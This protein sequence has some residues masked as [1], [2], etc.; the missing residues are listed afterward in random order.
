MFI[1]FKAGTFDHCHCDGLAIQFHVGGFHAS[2]AV[3]SAQCSDQES[4]RLSGL[5]QAG[6]STLFQ[7]D[8]PGSYDAPCCIQEG[9]S[10][11][12]RRLA[13]VGFSVGGLDPLPL[14]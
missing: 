8:R 11:V 14:E 3:H 4:H 13:Q 2:P 7:L 12:F 9:L 6:G 10:A 1:L 5:G